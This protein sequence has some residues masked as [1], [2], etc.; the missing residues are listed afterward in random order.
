MKKLFYVFAIA[1]FAVA[2]NDD[3]D[4]R[5]SEEDSLRMVDSIAKAQK[6]SIEA[7]SD[8]LKNRVD[9]LADATKDSIQ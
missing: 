8:S 5:M 1:A 7:A 4:G 6:D 9:S 3:A 2:C